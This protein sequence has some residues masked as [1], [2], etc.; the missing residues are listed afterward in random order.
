[1]AVQPKTS[2]MTKMSN[3]VKMTKFDILCQNTR[4]R[5]RA[6]AHTARHRVTHPGTDTNA[7]PGT[8]V[9]T[10][11][12]S[13]ACASDLHGH[14]CKNDKIVFFVQNDENTKFNIFG[15]V[16]TAPKPTD[17]T[18]AP[19]PQGDRAGALPTCMRGEV[20]GAHT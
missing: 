5:V 1:M 12:P 16:A 2:K 7:G 13:G 20:V 4:W 19:V 17:R 15:A 10:S 14:A 18:P 6:N 3:F 11:G 9:C 8:G